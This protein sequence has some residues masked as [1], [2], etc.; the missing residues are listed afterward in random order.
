MSLVLA[1]IDADFQITYVFNGFENVGSTETIL[2]GT[3]VSQN[4]GFR[5]FSFA[6]ILSFSTFR[7]SAP[8]GRPDTRNQCF[9][10][11]KHHPSQTTLFQG[12]L[13]S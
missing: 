5:R 10:I 12:K 1:N 3:Q 7:W 13:K 11:K 4:V 6:R 9:Y 8:S 2:S